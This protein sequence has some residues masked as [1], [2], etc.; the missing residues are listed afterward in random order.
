[1][2][3]SRG[4]INVGRFIEVEPR[5]ILPLRFESDTK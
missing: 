3:S 5:V 4:A 1:M 2:S